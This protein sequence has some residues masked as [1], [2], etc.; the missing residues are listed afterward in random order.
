VT[1]A[2]T[3]G[4]IQFTNATPV[5]FEFEPTGGLMVLSGAWLLSRHLKKK[6]STKV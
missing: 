1:N 2:F 6:K 4:N 3:G 5:P